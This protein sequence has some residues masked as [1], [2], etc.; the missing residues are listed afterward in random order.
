MFLRGF[1]LSSCAD[2]SLWACKPISWNK[3]F[4]S[5]KFFWSWCLSQQQEETRTS[6][7]LKSPLICHTSVALEMSF[8]QS[9][10]L[11][12]HIYL[13]SLQQPNPKA[14]FSGMSAQ[15]TLS[16][17]S[18]EQELGGA[19]FS[20]AQT[21]AHFNSLSSLCLPLNCILSQKEFRCFIF[22]PWGLGYY[23]E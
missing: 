18:L 6:G 17:P 11:S 10:C 14:V 1:C 22:I 23:R 5:Y 16:S 13:E 3:S 8:P 9:K 2:F 4:S 7:F 15:P 20:R 21:T 19:I 12:I